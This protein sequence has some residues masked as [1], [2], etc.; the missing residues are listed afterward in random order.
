M[1]EYVTIV[2]DKHEKVEGVLRIIL[3]PPPTCFRGRRWIEW[4]KDDVRYFARDGWREVPS[5]RLVNVTGEVVINKDILILPGM[6][7]IGEP[8]F[9]TIHFHKL[10]LHQLPDDLLDQ[11]EMYLN[12]PDGKTPKLP[13]REW[14]TQFEVPA[15][16]VMREGSA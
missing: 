7:H 10:T 12:N 6:G 15:L 5:P 13:F 9:E 16:W 1:S 11:F 4:K 2:H 14:L 8:F 3:E